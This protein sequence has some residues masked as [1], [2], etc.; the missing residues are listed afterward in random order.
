MGIHQYITKGSDNTF[1][2][3]CSFDSITYY[4]PFFVFGTIA[5]KYLKQFHQLMEHRYMFLFVL[6]IAILPLELNK[7]LSVFI[8]FARVL[9]VYQI[10]YHYKDNIEMNYLN[11]VLGYIGKHT[12]EV[13]FIH[14]F[15]LFGLPHTVSFL[16][17]VSATPI[18]IVKGCTSFL[19]LLIL[20]PLA[21]II[22]Y[23]CILIK[24]IA[25]CVPIV[26]R[27]CFGPTKD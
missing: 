3:T 13:Y 15:L 6:T 19:E 17:E 24:K 20:M 8:K 4:F 25:D 18:P 1:I 16:L 5:K 12:L 22:A 21:V 27:L 23:T 10:F 11:K 2:A 26:S 7:L 9:C 14:Y